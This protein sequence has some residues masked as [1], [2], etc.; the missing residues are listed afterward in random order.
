MKTNITFN[1]L[2]NIKNLTVISIIILVCNS[3]FLSELS[4]V[5][6]YTTFLAIILAFQGFFDMTS[7]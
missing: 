2:K 6:L 5:G 3:T 7:L 4:S 1:N